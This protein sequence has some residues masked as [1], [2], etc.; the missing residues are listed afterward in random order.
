[1]PRISAEH[2]Q[3]V[4]NRILDAAIRVFGELGYDRASIQDVVRESGLSVG[5]V[6]T[7][8]KGKEEL[9]L[10][11]CACELERDTERLQL[12]L[13]ELGALPDR[14]RAAVDWAVSS[15]IEGATSKGAL[16]H[17][18]VRAES[19]PEIRELLEERRNEMVRFAEGL[20]HEA[21]ADG[22]LPRWIDVDGVA[23]AFITLINGF[24]VLGEAGAITP[25]E[26]RREG[27]ALLELLLAAPAQ[28]PAAVDRLTS[29][30]TVA[31]SV[32]ANP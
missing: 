6:Y 16:V 15:S 5:A 25:D 14:L 23:A 10:T 26:A 9:F 4:R 31:R 29:P 17:A 32:A 12:R 27:Y 19:S 24:V 13:A 18:W 30:G 1:M 2:E 8:F 7:Y 28:R 11:S 22:E 3:A 20:L 21:V